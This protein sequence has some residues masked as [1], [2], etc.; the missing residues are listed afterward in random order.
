MNGFSW[1]D[2]AR[3]PDPD[4]WLP[5]E[6]NTWDALIAAVSV[7]DNIARSPRYGAHEAQEII[8]ALTDDY[9]AEAGFPPRPR[10][11]DW[12]IR[13]APAFGN[14]SELHSR[15]NVF[16]LSSIPSHG[17]LR[18]CVRESATHSV[19]C[20]VSWN[21]RPSCYCR[22][23]I[24]GLAPSPLIMGGTGSLPMRRAACG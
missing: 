14:I 24:A 2:R 8:D 13:A 5:L 6:D 12:F 18:S 9:L 19:S 22:R 4:G 7:P 11:F 16:L 21:L 10:G 17:C 1:Q 23:S 3:S 15:V 20:T